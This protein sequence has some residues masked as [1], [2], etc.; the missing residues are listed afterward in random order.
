MSNAKRSGVDVKRVKRH[1]REIVAKLPA[2][3]MARYMDE[4]QE[5]NRLVRTDVRAGVE[6]MMLAVGNLNDGLGCGK[7]AAL[8][9]RRDG[10]PAGRR[11]STLADPR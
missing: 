6:Q 10:G 7:D 3:V 5:A 4:M 2:A 11:C 1:A 8:K 9:A